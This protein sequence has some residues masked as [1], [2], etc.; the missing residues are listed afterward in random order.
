MFIQDPDKKE[1]DT[2]LTKLKIILE[3]FNLKH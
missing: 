2:I 3:F 1:I